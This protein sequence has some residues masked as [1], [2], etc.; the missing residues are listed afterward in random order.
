MKK[1][2]FRQ[3]TVIIITIVTLTMNSLATTLPLNN[4]TTAELSDSFLIRFVP[5]GYVF[6]VWGII[7]MGLIAFTV[8]QALPKNR[9]DTRMRT[10]G[11]WFVIGSIANTFWLVF[12][13][14]Q[15]V[16]ITL[17]I[18]LVLLATLIYTANTLQ[19]IPAKSRTE[20]LCVDLPFSI[21]MGWISVATVVNASVVLFDNGFA[22]ADDAAILWAVG[23][24]IVAAV[25]AFAQRILRRDTAYGMV[26]AWALYGV[27]VKQ[28]IYS[29]EGLLPDAPLLITTASYVAQILA[30]VLLIW[31]VAD[32]VSS[33][34]TRRQ[35]A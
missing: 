20:R 34:L 9:E 33:R 18:M 32:V 26:I 35:T 1:D 24:V 4:K 12:W 6:S 11:W 14:Y 13:H 25:L 16:A 2:I 28:G 31:W 19:K 17:P 5:A 29:R 8:W 22:V 21:Y 7:Y 10:I 15:H 23:L 3:I 27:A 30:T